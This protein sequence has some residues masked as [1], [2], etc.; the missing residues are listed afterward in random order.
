AHALGPELARLLRVPGHVGVG[1]HLEPARAVRPRQ[2]LRELGR[3]PGLERG[4]AAQEHQAAR[5]V[6]RDERAL[7][8]RVAVDREAARALADTPDTQHLPMPRA[9]TAAW[10]VMPPVAVRIP[11]AAAMPWMSSGTVSL[12]TSTTFSPRAAHFSASSAVN[13]ALPTAA[14]G[15]AARP[16]AI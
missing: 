12:R 10:L 8:D 11:C 15:E 16:R 7:L 5:A 4:H 3:E 6:E 14:P 2:E 13:T 9:T 1:A